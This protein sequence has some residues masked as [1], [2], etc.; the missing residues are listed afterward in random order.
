MQRLILGIILIGLLWA[1]GLAAYIAD[2][3]APARNAPAKTEAVAVYTGG[4]GAR[5]SA[6]MAVFANGGGERLLISG[7]HPDTTRERLSELWSGNSKLFECC[8]DLGREARSTQGNALELAKWAGENDFRHVLLVTSE[9]HM[10][11]AIAETRTR[12]PDA[13]IMPYAVASGYLD[14]KGRPVSRLAWEKLAGEYTKFLLARSKS[15]LNF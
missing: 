11:R 10:P 13:T 8:V 12:L 5:I 15:L 3:P 6:G 14:E 1:I 9:Y 7:V 4:G 2:L